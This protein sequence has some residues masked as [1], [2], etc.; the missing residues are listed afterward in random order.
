[1][2]AGA[3]LHGFGSG[4]RAVPCR[5][6]SS[7]SGT[8]DHASITQ[9]LGSQAYRDGCV[10]I[11]DVWRVTVPCRRRRVSE[12][13]RRRLQVTLVWSLVAGWS[14]TTSDRSPCAP[15]PSLSDSAGSDGGADPAVAVVRLAVAARSMVRRLRPRPD[16]RDRFG[17]FDAACSDVV[18]GLLILVPVDDSLVED[19]ETEASEQGPFALTG[20]LPRGGQRRHFAVGP[21]AVRL[22]AVELL[23]HQGQIAEGGPAQGVRAGSGGQ[24]PALVVTASTPT[25]MV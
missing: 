23:R 6:M 2:P 16:S 22:G 9:S 8:I 5:R 7:C 20:V 10:G 17:E 18:L 24:G 21:G 25:R 3:T 12:Q 19:R 4:Q 15:L 1:M 14:T 13:A 11:H